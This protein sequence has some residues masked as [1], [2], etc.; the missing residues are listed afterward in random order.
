MQV[1][2]IL[3]HTGEGATPE[4]VKAFAQLAE[5]CGFQGLWG[6]DHLVLPHHVDSL[7]P[8]GRT[9]SPVVD[10]AVADLL[11]PNLELITTLTWVAAH[12]DTIELGTSVAVLPIRN[13]L[14]NAR[15][16][17]TLDRCSGGRLTYGVG[18]GWLEEEARALG[19]PWAERGR[20]TEEHIELLRAVW[21]S[22][23]QLVEFHGEFYDFDLIDAE[24]RPMHTI[25]I[26]IGGHSDA[27]LDRAARIGDGWIAAPMPAAALG[28]R[29]AALRSR[30]AAYGRDPMELRIVA[31]MRCG[32]S[33]PT[34]QTLAA[35]AEAGVDHLQLELGLP[36]GEQEL[37]AVELIGSDL[38]ARVP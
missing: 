36:R 22:A 28:D 25:P 18:I 2:L 10:G 17:A 9:P 33:P 6:V 16:L 24:P 37:E 34:L 30:A 1:G 15:Q 26:L 11:R 13:P 35:F 29:I 23:E 20:R 5:R 19:M 3:P 8:L 12:T 38:L 4:H 7:Y 14:T 27:A 31:S 32:G 21:T